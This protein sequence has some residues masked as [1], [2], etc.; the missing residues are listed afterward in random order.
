MEVY[1]TQEMPGAKVGL[2]AL[3]GIGAIFSYD[4]KHGQKVGEKQSQKWEKSKAIRVGR[5]ISR[6]FVLEK[7]A[8]N[9]LLITP[10]T[11]RQVGVALYAQYGWRITFREG[12]DPMG[13]YWTASTQ[14]ARWTARRLPMVSLPTISGRPSTRPR[15]R[16]RN[17]R[18]RRVCSDGLHG[19]PAFIGRIFGINV[20][21]K[22]AIAASDHYPPANPCRMCP[23]RRVPSENTKA[24]SRSRWRGAMVPQRPRSPSRVDCAW[25][26]ST[27]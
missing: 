15:W 8:R 25:I 14:T 24:P 21:L 20:D 12:G 23:G 27:R 3:P 18:A 4:I 13:P 9:C 16:S 1:V 5:Q 7:I 17:A 10:D 2:G 26:A 19:L 11:P 22:I 6:S